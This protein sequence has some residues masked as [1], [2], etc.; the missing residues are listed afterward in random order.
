MYRYIR[1][2]MRVIGAA[3]AVASF[4]WFVFSGTAVTITLS[5]LLFCTGVI[6][7][8]IYFKDT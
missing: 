4:V 6:T 1:Q 8:I 2:V 7:F 5:F 3:L